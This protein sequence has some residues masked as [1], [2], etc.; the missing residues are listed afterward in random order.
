MFLTI[1]QN[2]ITKICVP[3]SWTLH[4]LPCSLDKKEKEESK[5]S[6]TSHFQR[7]FSSNHVFSAARRLLADE[8]DDHPSTSEKLGYCAAKV[9]KIVL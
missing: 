9:L 1:T 2:R 4:M 8:G 7:F 3:E 5:L 6:S